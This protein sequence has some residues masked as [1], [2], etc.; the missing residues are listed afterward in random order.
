[1]QDPVN[2]DNNRISQPIHVISSYYPSFGNKQTNVIKN[3]GNTKSV[4]CHATMKHCVFSPIQL[5]RCRPLL[6]IG[7]APAGK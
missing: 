7:L 4:S 5:L 6:L 3:N 2:G 1:M